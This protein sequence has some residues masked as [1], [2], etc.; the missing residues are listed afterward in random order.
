MKPANFLIQQYK[1]NDLDWVWCT[2]AS[3]ATLDAA[4]AK[5][6]KLQRKAETNPEKL[7]TTGFRVIQVLVHIG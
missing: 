2:V 1:V 5:G 6:A 3:A 7:E 4:I